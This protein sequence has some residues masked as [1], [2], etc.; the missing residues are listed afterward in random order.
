MVNVYLSIFGLILTD[1]YIVITFYTPEHRRAR[2]RCSSPD[3]H[4]QFFTPVCFFLLTFPYLGITLFVFE[5]L[6][7]LFVSMFL[8][9]LCKFILDVQCL[10][11]SYV[12]SFYFPAS[13]CHCICLA[14]LHLLEFVQPRLVTCFTC[15][16]F[17]F[18]FDFVSSCVV[19]LS[20]RCLKIFINEMSKDFSVCLVTQ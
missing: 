7:H 20:A 8:S 6:W 19:V 18:H 11:L 1:A 4:K 15:F 14:L 12:R 13:S 5:I 3:H 10:F 9:N 17:C 2:I 16:L